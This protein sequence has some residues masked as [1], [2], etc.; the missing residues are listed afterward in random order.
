M[1]EKE[2]WAIHD[3]YVQ[4]ADYFDADLEGTEYDEHEVYPNYVHK[5]VSEHK[6]AIRLLSKV[7]EEETEL[8]I[9]RLESWEEDYEP[10]EWAGR[11]GR[12]SDGGYNTDERDNPIDK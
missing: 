7:L 3:F 5:E 6:E 11:Y 10:S 1:E 8:P 12:I 9:D 2:Y 4:V